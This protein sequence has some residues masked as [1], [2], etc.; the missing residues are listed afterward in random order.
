M[1]LPS[2]VIIVPAD[3]LSSYAASD[4]PGIMLTDIVGQVHYILANE[5]CLIIDKMIY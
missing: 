3:A 1:I 2:R 5:I 4:W